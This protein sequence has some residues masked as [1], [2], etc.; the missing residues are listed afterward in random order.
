MGVFLYVIIPTYNASGTVRQLAEQLERELCDYN[1]R[2]AFIDDASR[3]NTPEIILS[4]A[5]ARPDIDYFLS[6]KNQGQQASLLKGLRMI[7]KPCEY[8]VTMDDD[9][10]HPVNVIPRLIEKIQ[11]GCDLV[12]A[13]PCKGGVGISGIPCTGV[14]SRESSPSAFRRLGSRFRDLLFEGFPNKPAG[15]R[16]SAFRIMTYDLAMKLAAS[17]KK[18]FYLSA[19]A[20]QY[21]IR[22]ANIPY[23]YVPRPCG[24]SSYH[25]GK[26][27]LIYFKILLSYRRRPT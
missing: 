3:D 11:E 19:E 8:V 17:K 22:A 25:F 23:E 27:L 14:N 4:L 18:F 16:V 2:I 12:Y 15:I 24:R 13:I 9:L 1:F 10:Q 5:D 26:L 20:F 6:P 21:K 7:P